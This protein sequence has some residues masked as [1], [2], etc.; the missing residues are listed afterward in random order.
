MI[1]KKFSIK[2]IVRILFYITLLLLGYAINGFWYM[3][4]EYALGMS[5]LAIIVTLTLFVLKDISMTYLNIEHWYLTRSDYDYMHNV[6]LR[7]EINTINIA[8]QEEMAKINLALNNIDVKIRYLRKSI[9]ILE[10]EKNRK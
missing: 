5:C 6:T 1:N 9:D 8:L 10:K 2:T 4:T 7:N 3:P